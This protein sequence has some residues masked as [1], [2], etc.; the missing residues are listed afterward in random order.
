MN[1]PADMENRKNEQTR[2]KPSKVPL[3]ISSQ[4]LVKTLT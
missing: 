2:N 3:Y 4:N 1:G